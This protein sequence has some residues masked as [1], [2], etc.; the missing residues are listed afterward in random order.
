[1]ARIEHLKAFCLIADLHS[2]SQAAEQC[3]LSQ[4][5]LSQQIKSLEEEYQTQLLHRKGGRIALTENGKLLYE[6]ALKIIALYEHSLEEVRPQNNV[7]EGEL[8]LG[9]SSGPGEFPVPILL[10][11]YKQAHP[12]VSVSLKAGD[13]NEIIDQVL[14]HALEIGFVGNQRPDSHLSFQPF[15]D[16][17]MVLVLHPSHP[18]TKRKKISIQEF[19]RIPLILQQK[20]AGVRETFFEALKEQGVQQGD[21]KVLMELGLQDSAKAAVMAGF[22]GAV[23]SRL[24]GVN[25]L[26]SGKLVEVEVEDLDFSRPM[27]LCTNRTLPLTNLASDFIVFAEANKLKVIEEYLAPLKTPKGK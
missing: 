27:Y 12:E 24:G 14:N 19:L 17:Q 8:I 23:I 11:M 7:L 16:D 10:G 18:L 22:G 5:A 2:F 3:G 21:V 13:T 4:P 15:F 1:M 9:A 6:Y 25:E 20:G 26:A